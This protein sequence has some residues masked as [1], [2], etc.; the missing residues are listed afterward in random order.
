MV[1]WN[2]INLNIVLLF[3]VSASATPLFRGSRTVLASLKGPRSNFN[4]TQSVG[5]G[6]LIDP[7]LLVQGFPM[8]CGSVLLLVNFDY[9]YNFNKK[10]GVLKEGEVLQGGGPV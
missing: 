2:G 7:F 4:S 6:P 1:G 8:A 5:P 9:D 10:Q 3:S